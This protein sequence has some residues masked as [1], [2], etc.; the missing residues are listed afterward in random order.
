MTEIQVLRLCGNLFFEGYFLLFCKDQVIRPGDTY[1]AQRSGGPFLL[2][3]KQ[4]RDGY[5]IP[6]ERAYPFNVHECVK[7]EIR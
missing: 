1:I 5:V 4:V 7:V 2:T 3:A 6:E